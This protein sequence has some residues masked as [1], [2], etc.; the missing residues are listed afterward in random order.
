MNL[1]AYNLKDL[2]LAAIKSEVESRIVYETVADKVR[3]AFLKERLQ[4][5]A[6]EEKKHKVFIEELFRERFPVNEIVLPKETPV[7]LPS[8]KIPD[9]NTPLSIVFESAMRAERVSSEFYAGLTAF[10]DSEVNKTL[11]YF[12]AMEMDHYR[13]LEAEL[14]MMKRFEDF[15]TEWPMMNVGP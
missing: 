9:E 6:G 11:F 7:P 5:L 13:I 1:A 14:E 8:V 3:N 10:F 4:F 2:L 12:A 15:D